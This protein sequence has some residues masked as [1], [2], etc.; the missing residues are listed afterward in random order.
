MNKHIIVDVAPDGSVTI[1]AMNF[2]G[3]ECE[4]AT[5]FLDEALGKVK[6]K[7]RTGDFYKKVEQ[8]TQAGR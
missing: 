7:K 1:E 6:D 8:K 4:K 3:A 2:K 5:R